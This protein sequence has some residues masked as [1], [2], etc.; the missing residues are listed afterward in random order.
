MTVT[1]DD[2]LAGRQRAAAR[3]WE[4]AVAAVGSGPGVGPQIMS[5]WQRSQEAR[6][7]PGLARAPVVCR[8]EDLERRRRDTEWLTLARSVL[9]PHLP[10]IGESGH[11]LTLFGPDGAMLHSDG[12][13]R[14]LE[15]LKDIHFM[16]G[17]CWAEALVGTNGP[18]TALATGRP[19]HVVGAEHF[20]E[21]WQPWHCAA[22][23]IRAPGSGVILGALDLSGYRERADGFALSLASALTKELEAQL[24]LRH[25]ARSR[26]VLQHFA[27]L[28]AHFPS[29]LALAVDASGRVLAANPRAKLRFELERLHLPTALSHDGPLSGTALPAELLGAQVTVVRDGGLP[30]GACILVP[31]RP[32]VKVTASTRYSFRDLVGVSGRFRE[33]ERLARAAASQRLPVLIQGESG[34]GKE[35]FAQAI[36]GLSTRAGRPFVPVNCAALPSGLIES[37]LFGYVGG[38]FSGASPEG[39]GGKF[40]AADQGTLFLDEV[41]ELP[42]A[43]QAVLL[44]VLQE[45]EVTPLGA[46]RATPIDVRVIAA[47]NRPLLAEVEAGRFRLDLYHRLAVLAVEIPPLR[48]RPEDLPSLI[49]HLLEAAATETGRRIQLLPEVEARL[50]SYPWPGNVRELKNV[51]IRLAATSPE[52]L[53]TLDDLPPSLVMTPVAAPAEDEEVA[54]LKSAVDRSRTMAEAARL[55][56]ITRSTLYRQLDRFGL[57]RRKVVE[58]ED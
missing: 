58:P 12:D 32:R 18:G 46:H 40:Q 3:A 19:V 9:L 27:E 52:E 4:R 24:V 13:L 41:G 47:T 30:I 35:L 33:A 5:S 29:E 28:A 43:A 48:D 25:E 6:V 53:V 56:G 21:A 49:E 57:T 2:Q 44:R 17:A 39:R 1:P 54:R 22:V 26:R 51:L 8:D 7:E 36:H 16:P 23:P 10:L 11:V 42:P 14:V 50:L 34:V 38:A 45:G 37:E 20:V 55:L 15:V 31:E